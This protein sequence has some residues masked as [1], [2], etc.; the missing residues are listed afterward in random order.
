MRITFIHI[1]TFLVLSG[2]CSKEEPPA[3]A[4]APAKVKVNTKEIERPGP[5][6]T[7]AYKANLG[8][9]R[10]VA[11]TELQVQVPK[12]WR[13]FG[14]ERM[15]IF[16]NQAQEMFLALW[17]VNKGPGADGKAFLQKEALQ[18]LRTPRFYSVGE[19]IVTEGESRVLVRVF[20]E[21]KVDGL[22]VLYAEGKGKDRKL[23]DPRTFAI[24]SI[25]DA[26]GHSVIILGV[27]T[28][29]TYVKLR[30]TVWG[31]VQSVR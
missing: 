20:D 26:K 8:P 14:D 21:R 3:P 24:T 12:S 16:D 11:F 13:E 5:A 7:K 19:R 6:K 1:L 29:N 9:L 22:R 15:R 28:E 17:G 27:G 10:G 18:Y 31:M 25:T 30:E 23:R 2:G 4:P